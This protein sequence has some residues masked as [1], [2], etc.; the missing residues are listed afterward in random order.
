MVLLYRSKLKIYD[1]D[2]YYKL[3]S[4]SK[5]NS[6]TNMVKGT[7][8]LLNIDGYLVEIKSLPNAV[9]NKRDLSKVEKY[10]DNVYSVVEPANIKFRLI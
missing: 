6:Y 9:V 10:I 7:P 5:S 3:Y 2:V 8:I 1:R 4:N